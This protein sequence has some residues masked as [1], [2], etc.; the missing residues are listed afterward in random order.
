MEATIGGG[1]DSRDARQAAKQAVLAGA[2]AG[3]EACSKLPVVG[4]IAELLIAAKVKYDEL[5][6]TVE[7]TEDFERWVTTLVSPLL[8]LYKQQGVDPIVDRA[9]EAAEMAVRDLVELSQHVL[10]NR[11]SREASRQAS[12][13]AVA[14]AEGHAASAALAGGASE[15]AQAPAAPDGA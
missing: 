13:L 4:G 3:L 15:S 6:D 8:D 5:V 7:E 2:S 9:V 12:L 14:A 1:L 11:A 10:D